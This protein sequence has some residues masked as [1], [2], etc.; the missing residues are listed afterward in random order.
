MTSPMDAMPEPQRLAA[1][2][3]I[4]RSA[5]PSWGLQGASL[6]LI[7]CRENAVFEVMH[8]AQQRAALR[9]HRYGY[10]T[11]ASLQ[12]EFVW[13]EAL[14]SQ[15][16]IMAR[17]L[18]TLQG[19]ALVEVTTEAAPVPH[20]CDLLEWIDGQPLGRADNPTTLGGGGMFERY[21]IVG[22]VAG[23][24]HRHS[25]QWA[26]PEGF[27]RPHWDREG[28]LGEHALWGPWA[29]LASLT[30]ADRDKISRAVARVDQALQT[31][32]TSRA[33][34]GMV[35]ADFVPDNLID[36][37]GQVAVLDLD[38]AG[39]GWYLW[40]LVTAVFWYLGTSHYTPA[41]DGYLAGYRSVLP[42]DEAHLKLIPCFLLMR[43]L[44]YMG[45][46]ETRRTQVTARLLT[47]RVRELSL[48]LA[49][50]VL[51]GHSDYRTI[52]LPLSAAVET[53]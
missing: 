14:R 2:E 1:F 39:Y 17:N 18:P 19:E 53:E 25:M 12:S 40:E 20:L 23:Q 37:H 36:S 10:H 16:V 33:V 51:A 4:A 41:L 22:R 43:A 26:E 42:I 3:Q 6:R 7:A 11:P 38:D 49:D 34:Y 29:A 50:L 30:D 13:M 27:E 24:I 31:L 52:E 44:V 45:W 47:Q 48:A 28:C 21:R 46:M 9:V 32:G 5:L 8:G 35:H 15:G